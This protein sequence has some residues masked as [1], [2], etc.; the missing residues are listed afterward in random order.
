MQYYRKAF[1]G[2]FLFSVP[3]LIAVYLNGSYCQVEVDLF[4]DLLSLQFNTIHGHRFHLR[5]GLLLSRMFPRR[6]RHGVRRTA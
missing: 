6:Q 4:G 3:R 2:R 5:K 1:P